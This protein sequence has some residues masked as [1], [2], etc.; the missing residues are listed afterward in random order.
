[1]QCE[2]FLVVHLP[3]IILQSLVLPLARQLSINNWTNSCELFPGLVPH[4]LLPHS[5]GGVDVVGDSPTGR[6]CWWLNPKHCSWMQF[7][8]GTAVGCN[9]GTH[10]LTY[11]IFNIFKSAH[12]LHWRTLRL[13]N[14]SY[15]SSLN[16]RFRKRWI[17]AIC[18]YYA[19]F[20]SFHVWMNEILILKLIWTWWKG[21][22][23]RFR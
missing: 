17:L 14:L 1:M 16:R 20:S 3:V 5:W 22:Y 11:R 7:L 12:T 23:N 6:S 4:W 13:Y 10:H 18:L 9:P 19:W 21:L 2:C 15:S 8:S